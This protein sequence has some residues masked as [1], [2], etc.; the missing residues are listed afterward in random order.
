MWIGNEWFK[1]I[2]WWFF[3]FVFLKNLYFLLVRLEIGVKEL[4][5]N[6]LEIFWFYI[7]GEF[8]VIDV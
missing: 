2:K 7:D 5:F 4:I 1:Y 8:G 3:F 6:L